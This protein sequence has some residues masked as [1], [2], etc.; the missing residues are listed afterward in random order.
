MNLFVYDCLYFVSDEEVELNEEGIGC[1]RVIDNIKM[2]S[3][4]RKS[5]KPLYA[6]I[7][8]PTRELAVQIKDHLT[9]I[10]KY[11]DLKVLVS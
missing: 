9:K 4:Q 6:L 7:L 1:V 8:T 10:T 5:E 3:Q 2:E 11:T